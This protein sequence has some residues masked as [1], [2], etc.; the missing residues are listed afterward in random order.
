MTK[1]DSI[2]IGSGNGGLVGALNLAKH[3]K[4]VLLLEKHNVPGG[5]AT[6]FVRGRFEFDTA[7]H[8]LYGI[9]EDP[10]GNKGLLRKIFEK[11][12]IYNKIKFVNQEEAFS[13]EV[14]GF[15]GV[16]V[17]GAKEGFVKILQAV[18]PDEAKGIEL[19]QELVNTAGTEYDKLYD[20]LAQDREITAE[21]FPCLFEHG[22][23]LVTEVMSE[24]FKNPMVTAAY[25]VLSDYAGMPIER[26]PFMTYASVYFRGGETCNVNGGSQSISSAIVDEF[27]SCGGTFMCNTKV[28]ELLIEDGKVTG[29]LTTKGD[30]FKADSVLCNVNKTRVYVDMIDEKHVSDEVF[31]N[32]KVSTPAESVFAVFL[33]LNCSYQEAGIKH[34]TNFVI[35]P[36]IETKTPFDVTMRRT[37]RD[38]K[39]LYY[40]CYNIDDPEYSD[41]GTCVIS[42]LSQ[43][44]SEHWMQMAPAQYHEEKMKFGTKVLDFF[45]DLYPDARNH[46]EEIEMATPLTFQNYLGSLGGS[47]YAT[48]PNIKDYI[49][50]KLEVR[51]PIKGL[52]FCGCSVLMGGFDMTYKSGKAASDLM[53]RDFEKEE[54]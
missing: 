39:G 47:I 33:G 51:S 53:L 23:K 9:N 8:Q 18:S 48:E 15:G 32:L 2:V 27:E 19:F 14:K 54:K 40:S 16:A 29:V 11:L 36:M 52:Y 31:M 28:K 38:I 17:P 20:F 3:G 49:A 44:T 34:G 30:V 4:K 43:Q 10:Y 5:C 24:H 22:G 21:D 35:N 50:N 37:D 1:Y 7:L 45:L 6:T 42:M 12:G 25:S 13:V 46:I 41:P 26:L